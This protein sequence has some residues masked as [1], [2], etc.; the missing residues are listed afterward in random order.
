MDIQ[1]VAGFRLDAAALQDLAL[2][3]APAYR[4]AKPFPHAVFDDFLPE[5]LID[6][7]VAEFPR[8]EDPR[9]DLYTDQG[10][11][12]KVATSDETLMGPVTRQLIAEFNGKAMIDFLEALTGISGLVPDPHLVGG[13]L[14]QLNPGGFL[15]VHADFNVHGHLKLDRRINLLLYLNR[16]WREE[17]GGQLELWN[18]DMSECEREVLPIANRCVIFNTT[19]V[20]FHGNPRPV[21][22]PSGV[23]RRSLAF[24]Y[25]SNGRPEEE[26]SNAHSTLYQTPGAPARAPGDRRRATR[27]RL[28][29]IARR[30]LPPIVIDAA[31]RVR[32]RGRHP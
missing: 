6:A 31:K 16:D 5:E 7:C 30:W 9:W 23:A 24:Y 27:S 32:D 15:R 29:A 14:H 10:N 3:R 8:E 26:R 18:R 20:S 25:Y 4:D 2:E 22:C 21:A 17:Y 1:T 13:G 11:S 12:F 28:R 19:S